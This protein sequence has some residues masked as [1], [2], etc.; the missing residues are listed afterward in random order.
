MTRVG[1]PTL[2]F[3]EGA[4]RGIFLNDKSSRGHEI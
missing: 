1:D 2:F 4:F 3:M